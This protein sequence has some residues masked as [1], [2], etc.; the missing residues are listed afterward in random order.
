[1]TGSLAAN[2]VVVDT[3]PANVTF[4]S[5]GSDPPGTT[6]IPPNGSLLTWNLPNL[7]PGTYDLFY[8]AQVN[9]FVPGGTVLENKAWVT[10]LNGGPIT[11]IADVTVAGQYTI[12]V[13]VYNE[14]GEVVKTILVTQMSQPIM[15]I[16]LAPATIT[17]LEGQVLIYDGSYLI[18]TWDGTT[19][20]GT[21]A[22]NGVY[23]ISVDS[24]DS[25]GVVQSVTQQ[26]VVSRSIAQVTV[27]IYNEAGEVVRHLLA[28]VDDPNNSS[29]TGFSLSSSTIVPGSSS[30]GTPGQVQITSNLGTL[31]A[32]WDGRSDSGTVVTNGIYFVEVTILNGTGGQSVITKTVTVLQQG[33]RWASGTVTA[34]PNEADANHPTIIFATGTNGLTLEVRIYDVAGELVANIYGGAGTSQAQWTPGRVAN[35]IY[36]AV[37]GLS[38]ANGK[39][40]GQQILKLLVRH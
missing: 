14:A 21:P 36:I 18:G 30:P 20:N 26:A 15:N 3:L 5:Y 6:T 34:A 40:A 38:D 28:Y 10:Y 17:S 12:E 9:S 19:N 16:Q 23:H 8:T 39:W 35:G 1:V 2:P 31:L 37:V 33:I 24:L 32:A 27:D 25:S 7:N 4:N 11:A 29:I 13:N 22:T